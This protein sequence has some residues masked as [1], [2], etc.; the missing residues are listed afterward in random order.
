MCPVIIHVHRIQEKEECGGI[1]R[2]KNSFSPCTFVHLYII[3]NLGAYFRDKK[4]LGK[5]GRNGEGK[6]E[7]ETPNSTEGEESG[8]VIC[9]RI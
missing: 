7:T 3:I 5:T 9:R 1:H 4:A 6:A 8:S 2:K